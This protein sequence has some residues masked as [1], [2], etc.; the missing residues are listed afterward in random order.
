MALQSG[1]T[2]N[3]TSNGDYEFK[4]TPGLWYSITV[5]GDFD[6]GTVLLRRDASLDGTPDWQ[7]YKESDESTDIAWT[8][9]NEIEFRA[10]GVETNVNLAGATSPDI[11]VRLVRG[12]V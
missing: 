11:N 5:D 10:T 1:L 9:N 6:G 7:N 8:S 4:T 12:G 3:I 2:A